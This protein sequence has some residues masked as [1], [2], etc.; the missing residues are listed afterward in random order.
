MRGGGR[1]TEEEEEEVRIEYLTKNDHVR[2]DEEEDAASSLVAVAREE[3]SPQEVHRVS[4]AEA[5]ELEP[6]VG[7]QPDPLAAG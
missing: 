4:L 3:A 5:R 7:R 6:E 2:G 1:G